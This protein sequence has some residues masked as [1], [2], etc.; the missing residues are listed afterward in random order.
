MFLFDT[1]FFSSTILAHWPKSR[2]GGL[3]EC[4]EDETTLLGVIVVSE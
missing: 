1:T 3:T 2:V 4:T